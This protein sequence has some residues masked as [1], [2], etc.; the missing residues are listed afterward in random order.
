MTP[1]SPYSEL[2]LPKALLSS[3]LY[4]EC[5]VRDER[6]FIPLKSN[7]VGMEGGKKAQS[8]TMG[9]QPNSLVVT[10]NNEI[11]MKRTSWGVAV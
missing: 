4:G 2:L 3:A 5:D 8:I 1:Y 11:H 7:R 10:E 6:P 9:D